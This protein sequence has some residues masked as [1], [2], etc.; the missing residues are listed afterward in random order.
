MRGLDA[1]MPLWARRRHRI[2]HDDALLLA[3]RGARAARDDPQLAALTGAGL[4]I[5]VILDY[6]F[7][8]TVAISTA[9]FHR[10]ALG[11]LIGH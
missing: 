1:A 4:L 6:A 5:T 2:R 9:A 10:G 3:G 7:S 8:G 11:L